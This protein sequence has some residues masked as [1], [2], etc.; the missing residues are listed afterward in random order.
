MTSSVW[1]PSL[2]EARNRS[3]ISH[4]SCI[5]PQATNMEKIKGTDRISRWK[6]LTQHVIQSQ[7]DYATSCTNT[8][9]EDGTGND[10]KDPFDCSDIIVKPTTQLVHDRLQESIQEWTE[11]DSRVVVHDLD[12]TRQRGGGK[13]CHHKKKRRFYDV[14]EYN[15]DKE[16]EGSNQEE[17]NNQEEEED[18]ENEFGGDYAGLDWGWHANRIRLPDHFDYSCKGPPPTRVT[19]SDKSEK[20]RRRQVVSV[21]DATMKLDYESELWKIFNK[22]P[23]E[24][25]IEQDTSSGSLCRNTLQIQNEI[26]KGLKD[27]SRLDAHGLSRLRKRDMH[28]WPRN[29]VKCTNSNSYPID[30]TTI[31]IEC[32]RRS[33]KRNSGPEPNRH[34]MEFLG[35]QTLLDVH[36]SMVHFGY[37]RLFEYGKERQQNDETTNPERSK[38]ESSGFFFIEDTFY[39]TGNVDYVTPILNW[40]DGSLPS[41]GK[42]G[43]KKRK[44]RKS[45]KSRREFLGISRDIELKVVKME[46]QV[47]ETIRLRL[48][49]RYCHIYNG[50]CESAFFFSDVGMRFENENI[51]MKNYPL[52]HDIWSRPSVTPIQSTSACQ[53]C[54]HSTPVVL[55]L[56]DEMTDGGPSLLCTSCYMKLHYDAQDMK[57]KCNNFRVYPLSILYNL[58]ELSTGNEP[59]GVI[60]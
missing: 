36:K 38:H 60:F 21:Q 23:L 29:V 19:Q 40:L 15:E 11:L 48:G 6:H 51:P 22:V 4:V 56:E 49:V 33:L 34:E 8:K 35:T 16:E 47:L 14:S 18:G 25:E 59:D 27:Y 12:Y 30:G 58:R 52:I 10:E 44:A 20:T 26:E 45:K 32:W 54:E 7:T 2:L 42:P 5:M 9:Q 17:G 46:D 43:G 28:H 53:A 55:T 1:K 41:R 31:R 37:D 50:D 3:L 39:V 13:G 57:L 24:Q